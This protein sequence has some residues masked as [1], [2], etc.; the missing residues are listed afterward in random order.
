MARL[1][2]AGGNP[3]LYFLTRVGGARLQHVQGMEIEKGFQT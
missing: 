1:T 3:V 2:Y